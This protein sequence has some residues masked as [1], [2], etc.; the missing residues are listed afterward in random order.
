MDHFIRLYLE[1]KGIRL[2]NRFTGATMAENQ[3][4]HNA[5]IEAIR[6]YDVKVVRLWMDPVVDCAWKSCRDESRW[7]LTKVATCEKIVRLKASDPAGYINLRRK[8]VNDRYRWEMFFAEDQTPL[9][10]LCDIQQ[11][12]KVGKLVKNPNCKRLWTV[13]GV[14]ENDSQNAEW[15]QY[16]KPAVFGILIELGKEL[17]KINKNYQLVITSLTR[18]EDYQRDLRRTNSNATHGDTLHKFGLAIDISKIQTFENDTASLNRFEQ[19]LNKLEAQGKI[20]KTN[21]GY[22]KYGCFH[23]SVNPYNSQEYVNSYYRHIRIAKTTG[24]AWT[25]VII[26]VIIVTALFIYRKILMR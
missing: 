14:G 16:C 17:K 5:M 15:Y 18:T 3:R 9:E 11:L 1:Q 21:E 19:V 2:T 23:I 20:Y 13:N 26:L 22:G 7:Y 4:R 12:A 8:Y 6:K 10:H 25:W 24:K